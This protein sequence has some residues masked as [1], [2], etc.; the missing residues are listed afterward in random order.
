ME[1]KI[2]QIQDLVDDY[3]KLHPVK[4][5]L[6]TFHKNPRFYTASFVWSVISTA[7]G[8]FF[9]F[10]L[11][12]K[13]HTEQNK[14]K[15]LIENISTVQKQIDTLK[16][17]DEYKINA[18][19]ERDLK[20]NH[21]ILIET[22]SVYELFADL[23][24]SNKKLA[25]F[26]SRFAQILKYLSDKNNSSASAEIKKL[27]NEVRLENQAVVSAI[28]SID[29]SNLK[30]SNAP[31]GSGYSRQAVDVNGEKFAVDIV[32]ADMN[33]TRII[34]DTATDGDCADNCPVLSLAGY[35]GRNGAYAGI[36][37][38]YF[39]PADYPSCAGKS[40]SFDTLA[41]NKNKTYINFENNKYSTVP[42]VIFGNGFMRFVGAS[43][44]WGRDTGVD[45]VL[46]N[47]ALL[48][49]G[50]RSVF[51]G[52]GDPKKGSR[53]TRGFVANKGNMA[54][55]GHVHNSTVAEAALVLEKLGM[56]GAL[57][58][59]SGGSVALFVS[60]GY[61]VGPGRSI[62]NAILFVPK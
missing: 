43:Q 15:S 52:D 1:E 47:Q 2:E 42:A 55:I 62:P 31:P 6:K 46:A 9:F 51:G 25:D 34:V 30:S 17:R 4:Y 38:S 61:K 7:V 40:N 5:A 45:G 44:D 57:N 18:E 49:S 35:V 11:Q 12:G 48:V 24:A 60:G 3:K 27:T 32:A 28:A 19:L 50:G 33:S 8:L 14:T 13:L 41:M 54:Y 58:L 56:D 20:E 36:N 39:C 26:K 22:I 23:P 16:N 29:S 59:D 21:N 53:G 10:Q 37:G